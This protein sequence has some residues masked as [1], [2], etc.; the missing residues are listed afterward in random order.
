MDLLGSLEGLSL[1]LPHPPE[2]MVRFLSTL[3][4]TAGGQM[5]F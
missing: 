5:G 4:S 2:L 1:D 3:R